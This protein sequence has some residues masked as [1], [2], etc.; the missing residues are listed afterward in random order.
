M[1]SWLTRLHPQN[2][3]NHVIEMSPDI[4]RIRD[5]W[6]S[7]MKVRPVNC[8]SILSLITLH[9]LSSKCLSARAFSKV[10]M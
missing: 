10:V 5:K 1:K 2:I 6:T 7:M 4:S 8:S 3:T 9:S